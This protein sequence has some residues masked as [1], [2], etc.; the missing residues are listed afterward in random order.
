MFNWFFNLLEDIKEYNSSFKNQEYEELDL[1]EL[2]IQYNWGMKTFKPDTVSIKF[3][4]S[5][6]NKGKAIEVLEELIYIDSN[7]TK[8][9]LN[10]VIFC[11]RLIH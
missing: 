4:P 10:F 5:K 11:N 3:N 2:M 9:I 1:G 7:K 6:Y 8:W